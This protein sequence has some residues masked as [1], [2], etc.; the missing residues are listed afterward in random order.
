VEAREMI[1]H[2][3]HGTLAALILTA[4]ASQAG[5]QSQP[6]S[7][8]TATPQLTARVNGTTIGY[9]RSG[10]GPIAVVLIHGWPQSSRE[11]DEVAPALA[12]RHTVIAVDL[13]GVGASAAPA[14]GYEKA[15]MAADVQALVR[16]L[17]LR[18]TYVLGHDIGGMVAYAYARQYP[19]N[20]LGVGVFDVPL[21]GIEPWRRSGPIRAPGT[22]AFIRRQASPRRSS[23]ADSVSTSAIFTTG[24]RPAPVQSRIR[25]ST[26]LRGPMARPPL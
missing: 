21:P 24:F 10:D 23:G 25:N 26:H 11:W 1:R 3:L 20:L 2:F 13:R 8:Q 17:G 16:S 6:T 7:A 14:G 9:R 4:S 18:R 19:D 12:R 15:T 22:S 5:E